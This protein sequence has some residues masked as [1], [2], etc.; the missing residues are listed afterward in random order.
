MPSQDFSFKTYEQDKQILASVH[1]APVNTESLNA[2]AIAFHGGS[3]AIGSRLMIS[4]DHIGRLNELGFVVV[5]PDYRLCPQVSLYEG[6]QQDAKD[7]LKW[8]KTDLPQLLFQHG[9]SLDPKKVV[10]LGYSA[11]GNLALCLGHEKDRPR[12]ILDFYGAKCFTDPFWITPLLAMRQLPTFDDSFLKLVYDEPTQS[13]TDLFLERA[14]AMVDSASG[15]PRF[16]MS[17]PRVAWLFDSMRKGEQMR[18][19]VQ[20]GDFK[21]VDPVHHFS[22][23]FPPTFFIHGMA[24]DLVPHRFSEVAHRRLNELG[25]ITELSLLSGKSHGFDAGLSAEDSAQKTVTKAFEFLQKYA[26]NEAIG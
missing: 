6:P 16:D 18:L 26:N 3:F 11:G 8:C 25:V 5:A 13:S 21:R 15:M 24:D 2:V 17:V 23:S 14:A 4:A 7:V 1:W 12:A 10:A 20:D 19:L 22:A 9:L